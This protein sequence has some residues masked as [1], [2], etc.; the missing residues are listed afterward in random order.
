VVPSQIEGKKITRE[1]MLKLDK[2]KHL[3]GFSKDIINKY[4]YSRKSCVIQSNLERSFGV[5]TNVSKYCL[6]VLGRSREELLNKDINSVMPEY[7]SRSHE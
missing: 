1:I 6:E 4:I 5:I 2:L 3:K 7:F